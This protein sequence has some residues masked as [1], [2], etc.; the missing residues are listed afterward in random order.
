M[1]DRIRKS[2]LLAA[3]LAVGFAAWAGGGGKIDFQTDY[4][5]AKEAAAKDGKRMILYFTADW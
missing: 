5:K 3:G 1:G 4:A 2:L